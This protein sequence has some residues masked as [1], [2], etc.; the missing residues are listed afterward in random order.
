MCDQLKEKSTLTA[1]D[2][3]TKE[4]FGPAVEVRVE[5]GDIAVPKTDKQLMEE[6]ERHPG[7]IRIMEA[8]NAQM[9]SVSH[10]K[11]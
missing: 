1:L 6:A 10:R 4:Y 2:S 11:Q 7:V 9:L 3:L 5:T 8:F